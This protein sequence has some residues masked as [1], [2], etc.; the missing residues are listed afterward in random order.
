MLLQIDNDTV[1]DL[2]D[3]G[4]V[5]AKRGKLGLKIAKKG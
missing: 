5:E 3:T 1:R 2:G 4:M